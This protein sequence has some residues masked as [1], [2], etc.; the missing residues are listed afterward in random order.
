[1]VL[2]FGARRMVGLF[3]SSPRPAS[4]KLRSP[5][6]YP[7]LSL[8]EGASNKEQEVKVVQP[9]KTSALSLSYP[10]KGIGKVLGLY[11]PSKTIL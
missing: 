8:P 9:F 6:G 10:T 4:A 7:L 1:M 2:D 5:V 11:L 3:V